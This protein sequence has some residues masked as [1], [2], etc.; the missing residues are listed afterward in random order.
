MDLNL[1]PPPLPDTPASTSR[2]PPSH[3][4]SVF[5]SSP[6]V[7]TPRRDSVMQSY[8]TQ[9]GMSSDVIDDLLLVYESFIH[10]HWPILYVPALPSLRALETQSPLLFD[11][12][13]SLSSANSDVHLGKERFL[14]SVGKSRAAG[15]SMA[16]ACNILLE[17]VRQRILATVNARE[18]AP[19]I[20]EVQSLVLVA[21]VD[22]GF[23]RTSLAYQ[24]SGFACRMAVDQGL[25]TTTPR[26]SPPSVRN[27][28]QGREEHERSRTVW[29]CFIVDK[30]VSAVAQ[31]APCLRVVDMDVPQPS[32]MER[33]ELDLW[34]A[35]PGRH[36]LD[37]RSVDA[38]VCMKS[39]TLSSFNS[40][41]DVMSILELILDHIYRPSTRRAR[42]EGSPI[43]GYEDAVLHI[44][45]EL[46][47]WRRGLPPHLQ[48]S[49]DDPSAHWN[50]GQHPLTV[51]GWYYLCMLLLHRPQVPYL[52]IDSPSGGNT[53]TG[54][55]SGNSGR[56]QSPSCRFVNDPMASYRVP[57][58]VDASRL[59]ATAICTI[60]ESYERTFR[61][62]K[63]SSSWS[64]L[65]F[66][67]G[68]VHAGLAAHTPVNEHV[69]QSA[70]AESMRRLDQ[71]IRWLDHIARQWT[72]AGRHIE[73]LSKLA[74][75][76]RN[77]GLLTQAENNPEGQ[78][79]NQNTLPPFFVGQNPSSS[80]PR[81]SISAPPQFDPTQPGGQPN[82]NL[83]GDPNTQL[84]SLTPALDLN[85][86]MMLWASMPSAGDDIQLWQQCFP[87]L[88]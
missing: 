80:S 51:R 46:W 84:P 14:S 58:G 67:A 1:M 48:W 55:P 2:H 63:Y 17:S 74:A 39:H 56:D 36:L 9:A 72:S 19:T 33:D 20:E 76:G 77:A 79:S 60:M 25:N 31:R 64:Y 73:I 57:K 12:V 11:A 41:C 21:L 29:S 32:V 35:G 78:A 83:A 44:D 24:M 30:I 37:P 28:R 42:M 70:R 87:D 59:A 26:P 61:V 54:A 43:E 27:R 71:C 88:S 50:V 82:F 81:T 10:P 16:Q 6:R 18:Y 75:I 52:D 85:G 15:D 22:L 23:G 45:A 8:A 47:K 53:A 65:V 62:R 7:E 49:D 86:W 4:P 38:M 66:Q 13:L 34:L 69:S 40:W 68:T 5:A 3:T